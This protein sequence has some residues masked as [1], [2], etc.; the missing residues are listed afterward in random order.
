MKVYYHNWLGY[1]PL[2]WATVY[3][4]QGIVEILLNNA[5]MDEKNNMGKNIIYLITLYLIYE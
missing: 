1:T 2:H 3:D 4:H 5:S